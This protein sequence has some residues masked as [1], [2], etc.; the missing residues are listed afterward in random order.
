MATITKRTVAVPHHF[1]EIARTSTIF[2]Q[3]L[4]RA[5]VINQSNGFENLRKLHETQRSD[6]W[7]KLRGGAKPFYEASTA[8]A[9]IRCTHEEQ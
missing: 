5:Q 4:N 2:S 8:I 6:G 1:T 3:N 9:E 7:K